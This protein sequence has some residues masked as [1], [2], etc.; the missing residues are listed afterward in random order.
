ML[1]IPALGL[2]VTTLGLAIAA[3]NR[4]L[5]TVGLAI[6]AL[7]LAIPALRGVLLAI[8]TLHLRIL[9]PFQQLNIVN[10]NNVPDTILPAGLVNPLV[11]AQ[12]PFHQEHASLMDIIPYHI[13]RT[14]K[15]RAI[16]KA[17]LFA[18]LALGSAPPAVH[19]YANI[20]HL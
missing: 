14:S 10:H 18:V 7:G 1:T 16:D 19:R 2:T 11:H 3:L 12:T 5:L 8:T 6:T 15:R 13:A 9:T 17:G 4:I 20:H